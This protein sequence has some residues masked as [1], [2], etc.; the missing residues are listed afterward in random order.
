MI[1]AQKVSRLCKQARRECRNASNDTIRAKNYTERATRT[2][3][4]AL[5]A[6]DIAGG[7]VSQAGRPVH[8][9]ILVNPDDSEG[10]GTATISSNVSNSDVSTMDGNSSIERPKSPSVLIHVRSRELDTTTGEGS[11]S[12]QHAANEIAG[13][14]ADTSHDGSDAHRA[15]DTTQD[16][17]ELRA[18]LH[19]VTTKLAQGAAEMTAALSALTEEMQDAASDMQTARAMLASLRLDSAS[20][21]SYEIH[22]DIVTELTGSDY[23]SGGQVSDLINTAASGIYGAQNISAQQAT[24]MSIGSVTDVYNTNLA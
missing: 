20:V 16:V 11:L 23:F 19:V 21:K 8:D 15:G 9:I 18:R 7:S 1:H 5:L 22:P 12:L 17:G 4:N 14:R 6:A 2:A 24:M 10:E 3:R 13:E